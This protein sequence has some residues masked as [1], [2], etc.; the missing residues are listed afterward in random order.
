MRAL[1]KI[2]ILPVLLLLLQNYLLAQDKFDI[3][4]GKVSPADFDLS[5]YKF[6]TSAG[7]VY[8]CDKGVTE[9]AGEDN[10][11]KL[12]LKRQLRIKILNK[13]GFDAANFAISV[14]KSSSYEYLLRRI[15]AV[16]YNLENGKVKRV[17]MGNS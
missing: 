3:K 17:E 9:F 7:A 13:N 8:V 12:T 2:L 14:Y 15:D 10:G 4:F 11:L 6:D 1:L 5:A 16:T